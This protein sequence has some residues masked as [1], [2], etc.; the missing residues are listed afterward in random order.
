MSRPGR[1]EGLALALALLLTLPL[2]LGWLGD[3]SG[4]LL[5][6]AFQGGHAWALQ[7]VADSLLSGQ[8]PGVT[9]Q[10]GFPHPREA[11]WLGWGSHLLL[12]LPSRMFGAVAMTNLASWLGPALG[13][14][15]LVLLGRRLLPQVQ[16]P[17]LLA[18]GLLY[19]AS[20]T[21]LAMA[22]SGQLE[23]AQ[24]WV[25]PLLLWVLLWALEGAWIRLLAVL[26]LWLL[27]ACTSPYAAM[28]AG[29]MV[30]WL[31]WLRRA[32]WRRLLA[33]GALALAALL[34][35]RAYL[36]PLAVGELGA[37]FQPAYTERNPP[38]IGQPM[39]VADLD[40][41]LWGRPDRGVDPP[42]MHMPY[43]GLVFAGGALALGRWRKQ[44]LIPVILGVLLAL[45]PALTWFEQLVTLGDH[46]VWLPAALVQGLEL[47]L[48]RG[49]HYYRAMVLAH[50]GLGL[51][52]AS[53]R[54]GWRWLVPLV[55]LGAVDAGRS[56]ATY[57][58]PW[59]TLELPTRAWRGWSSAPPGAVLHLPVQ[60]RGLIANHP[61]RLAGHAVHGRAVSDL[62]GM[63]PE[64]GGELGQA[65]ACITEQRG[66]C[67]LDAG[68]TLIGQGFAVVALD[69]PD[70]SD[71]AKLLAG[72]KQGLGPP[73]GSE[74]GLVWWVLR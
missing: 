56:V 32:D 8:W 72:L 13:A 50:L 68:Q 9:G 21:T 42:L 25:L 28:F 37:V 5:H 59:P 54:V 38:L 31:I 36:D 60:G 40:T 29:M 44:A 52:L 70:E 45:G 73:A 18:G 55:L 51:L 7:V 27:G 64:P 35:A 62:P 57:G 49:G 34:L 15:A 3:P 41:L 20:P 16:A 14:P 6:N 58:L 69:T 12:L 61:V 1:L 74:D 23:K 48:A 11:A 22:G 10:A 4:R 65:I 30:P 26:P 47:P 43:L 71:R 33:G 67:D 24:A 46:Q 66:L 17:A 63:N 39:P 53:A 2:H 19:A